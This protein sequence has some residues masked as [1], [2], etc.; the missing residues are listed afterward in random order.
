MKLGHL[1]LRLA[2]SN[3]VGEGFGDGLARDPSGQAQLSIMAGIVGFGAMAGR[4]CH[5]A[6]LQR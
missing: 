5:T 4:F 1:L 2:K 3:R 6:E